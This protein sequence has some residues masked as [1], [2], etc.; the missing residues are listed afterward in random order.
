MNPS[1][2]Y[3]IG[4]IIDIILITST[5]NSKEN[6]LQSHNRVSLAVH[7]KMK[8]YIIFL[9]QIIIIHHCKVVIHCMYVICCCPFLL[10]L[11]F[12]SDIAGCG[13]TASQQPLT[14]LPV[15]AQL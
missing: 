11:F 5:T 7:I 9:T 13:Y 10:S 1:L 3:P 14:Y 15:C 6:V 2:L 4:Q 8:K 12:L